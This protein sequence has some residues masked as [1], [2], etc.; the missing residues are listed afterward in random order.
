M[1]RFSSSYLAL[2][3]IP[4]VLLQVITFSVHSNAQNFDPKVEDKVYLNNIE[5]G[6]TAEVNK[7]RVIFLSHAKLLDTLARQFVAAQLKENLFI[8]CI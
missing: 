8:V 3:L 4:I 6:L 1:R 7:T 2:A 5:K